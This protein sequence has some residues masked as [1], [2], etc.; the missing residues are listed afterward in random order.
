MDEHEIKELIQ[1]L[2]PLAETPWETLRGTLLALLFIAWSVRRI[3][4]WFPSLPQYAKRA[5]SWAISS[6][7]RA[8]SWSFD[9]LRDA[10]RVKYAKE[11]K[12]LKPVGHVVVL[13][14]GGYFAFV[15]SV[16]ALWLFS[17]ALLAEG[18]LITL[19]KRSGALVACALVLV[20]MR[21]LSVNARDAWCQLQLLFRKGES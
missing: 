1:M 10:M 3:I 8:V 14:A 13:V 7:A 12:W 19:P 5:T 21:I 18:E 20:M 16:E 15:A 2:T 4:D 6:T 9:K 17:Y 11:P